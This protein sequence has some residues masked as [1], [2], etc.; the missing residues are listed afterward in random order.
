MQRKN[1]EVRVDSVRADWKKSTLALFVAT[2]VLV[3]LLIMSSFLRLNAIGA[4]CF[5][6]CA[7]LSSA[8]NRLGTVNLCRL[9]AL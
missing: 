8:F 5:L 1:S 6:L 2:V 9:V 3:V 4:M 7:L